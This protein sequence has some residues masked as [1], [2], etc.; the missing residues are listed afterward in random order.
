MGGLTLESDGNTAYARASSKGGAVMLPV[1]VI[2]SQTKF[3]A[4]VTWS[5]HL[6]SGALE[7][8]VVTPFLSLSY[9]LFEYE[10]FKEGEGTLTEFEYDFNDV[11]V[12]F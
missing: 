12:G 7:I 5:V 1:E 9:T 4:K 6:L 11:P 2:E 8:K 3:G 10:G